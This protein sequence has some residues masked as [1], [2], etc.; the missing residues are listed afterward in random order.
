MPGTA[1]LGQ[2]TLRP[3]A[4]PTPTSAGSRRATPRRGPSRRIAV[5]RLTRQPFPAAAGRRA[6]P[7]SRG[8]VVW[9]LRRRPGS[10]PSSAE[11]GS[12]RR[13]QRSN[14]RRGPGTSGGDHVARSCHQPPLHAL[15]QSNAGSTNR[16]GPGLA[17]MARDRSATGQHSSPTSPTLG[18]ARRARTRHVVRGRRP[19]GH[20]V[21]TNRPATERSGRHDLT[22]GTGAD[23]QKR[24]VAAPSGTTRHSRDLT[25]HPL[26]AG[27]SPA[28]PTPSDLG[29]VSGRAL[30]PCPICP[31]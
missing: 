23:L 28:R 31:L 17:D 22:S 5:A 20:M 27:T 18:A 25:H 19:G 29:I 9:S 13:C 2:S 14:G 8:R 1:R 21:G 30:L 26:V 12:F 4:A 11:P 16:R 7:L 15:R 10:P 24:P 6:P 3:T